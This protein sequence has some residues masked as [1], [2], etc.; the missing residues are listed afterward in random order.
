MTLLKKRSKSIAIQKKEKDTPERAK[1][2]A[3]KGKTQA[4]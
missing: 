4:A 2:R 1:E 3:R